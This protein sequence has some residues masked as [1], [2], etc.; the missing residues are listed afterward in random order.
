MEQ[1][2][3]CGK[4]AE[5]PFYMRELGINLYSAEELSYVIYHNAL[6][7]DDD[8]FGDDLM[9]FLRDELQLT[10]T[11]EKLSRSYT[12]PSDRE[13]TLA[14]LLREIGYY[15]E[16]E[17]TKFTEQL[18]RF[19]RLGSAERLKEKGDLLTGKKR[20]ESAVRAYS[21]IL[22]KRREY[23]LSQEF[24]AGVLQHMGVAYLRMGYAEEALECLQAA[25]SETHRELFLEQMYELCEQNGLPYP[26]QLEQITSEQ[27][28]RWEKKYIRTEEKNQFVSERSQIIRRLE[29]IRGADADEK[30]RKEIADFLE[31]EKKRYRSMALVQ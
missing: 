3:L 30:R 12:G 11:A 2:Y 19:R 24:C 15:S 5:K 14:M 28:A 25:Y 13:S 26:A 17:I 21:S 9:A 27:M 8:F 6:L 22:T 20:Y 31:E 7:I 29:Q 10:Q 4:A 18:T 1:V 16:G 23:R